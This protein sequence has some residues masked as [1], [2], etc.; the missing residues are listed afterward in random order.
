ML[1]KREFR[2]VMLTP[3]ER[4]AKACMN[5]VV[6][7]EPNLNQEL[8]PGLGAAAVLDSLEQYCWFDY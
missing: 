6:V 8:I 4:Q 2:A 3:N 7:P 5:A 1:P